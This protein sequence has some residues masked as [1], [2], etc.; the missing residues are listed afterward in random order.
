MRSRFL[1]FV[2]TS[3]VTVFS[4]GCGNADLVEPTLTSIHDKIIQR[5]CNS[6]ACHGGSTPEGDLDLSTAESSY[7]ALVGVT[8][9]VEPSFTRVVQGDPDN[10]LLYMVLL[11]TVGSLDQMPPG[12]ALAADEVEAV[13]QWIEDGAEN[14]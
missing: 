13:R 3:L 5:S 8:S 10:S 6:E 1:P 9:D 2:L 12:F 11:G 7:A 4:L 14:N